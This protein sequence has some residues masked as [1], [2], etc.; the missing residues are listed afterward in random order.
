[1]AKIGIDIR[2]LASGRRTGVEEYTL[3]LLENIFKIDQKN[4]YILFFNSFK[5]Q[6]FCLTWALDY[7]NVYARKF[8]YPNKILNFF[9]WY[10][11]FPTIN[12]MLG[13]IDIL[14][15]P[16]L[17]F[18]SL[19]HKTKLAATIHDLSF[20]RLPETFS[21]KRRLWHAFVNP[22]KICQRADRIIAVSDSTKNDIVE[23]YKIA[24]EKIITL[25]SGLNTDFKLI[26]RND[27]KMLAVKEKYDLPYKFILHLGTVE[28]RKN[29]GSLVK[30]YEA[31]QNWAAKNKQEEIEKYFLV[32]AGQSGWLGEALAWQIKKSP[33]REKIIT[34]DYVE[35]EDKLYF[36]NL[37]SLFVY[38]SFFE[39]FGFPPLEAMACGVP[40]IASNNSSLPEIIGN[41]GILI[42]PDRP[43]EIFEAMKQILTNKE[44]WNKLH[45]SG[46]KQA[47]NFSW[48]KTAQ[49]FLKIIESIL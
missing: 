39:G 21:W 36:L 48:P 28:P 46:L 4:K 9:F 42:D 5:A 31:L 45:E 2:C 8:N 37:A 38:P 30:A 33:W 1:M 20:E 34:I 43:E 11:N 13:G 41:A 26:S 19:G 14:F 16:N 29:I 32:V 10:F 3:N 18:L 12:I 49:E 35:A 6:P 22:K 47:K 25:P 15:F 7:P 27:E 17:N 40:V 24:P 44:L 23:V